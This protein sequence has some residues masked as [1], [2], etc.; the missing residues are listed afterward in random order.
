MENC[1]IHNIYTQFQDGNWGVP[2]ALIDRYSCELQ[3]TMR[4]VTKEM[5]HIRI[6]KLNH[7]KKKAVRIKYI[8]TKYSSLSV[9]QEYYLG[10]YIRPWYECYQTSFCSLSDTM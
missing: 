3:S 6:E 2:M 10:G 5:D 4:E 7:V 8:F 9:I 1:Y